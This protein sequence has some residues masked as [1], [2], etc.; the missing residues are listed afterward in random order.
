MK[1]PHRQKLNAKILYDDPILRVKPTFQERSR[2]KP[3]STTPMV[4]A[5]KVDDDIEYSEGND[6]EIDPE[7][8]ED[9]TRQKLCQEIINDGTEELEESTA[10]SDEDSKSLSISDIK[11]YSRVKAVVINSGKAPEPQTIVLYFGGMGFAYGQIPS[12]KAFL[13]MAYSSANYINCYGE[14]QANE[15]LDWLK[16]IGYS[17]T[18]SFLKADVKN[19]VNRVYGQFNEGFS[20]K[21]VICV[22]HSFGACILSEFLAEMN[23]RYKTNQ[24]KGFE[25]FYQSFS[26]ILLNRPF[27]SNKFNDLMGIFAL[28]S[29][30]CRTVETNKEG[31]KKFVENNN[32]NTRLTFI[33]SSE[34]ETINHQSQR[35]FID[36]FEN[37]KI[38]DETEQNRLGHNDINTMLELLKQQ[39][40]FYKKSLNQKPIT[41]SNIAEK[42]KSPTYSLLSTSGSS[43]DKS[44]ASI[45]KEKQSFTR[46]PK[47]IVFSPQKCSMSGKIKEVNSSKRKV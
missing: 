12:T 42:E 22:T 45:L 43:T 4:E 31:I 34:D 6:E 40:G 15:R 28:G 16:L 35:A 13:K 47:N 32:S 46:Y 36:C 2:V 24:D 11:N 17:W 20:P 39:H 41:D 9:D 19:F 1:K 21:K 44:T 37:G 5:I 23:D 3:T 33:L 10:E 14:D 38:I 26:E 7:I 8:Q 25:K 27:V 29:L 18:E 30:A